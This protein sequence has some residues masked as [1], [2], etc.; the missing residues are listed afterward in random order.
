MAA[1]DGE[2]NAHHGL[3]P[4]PPPLSLRRVAEAGR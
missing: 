4:N 2:E 3:Q 1:T